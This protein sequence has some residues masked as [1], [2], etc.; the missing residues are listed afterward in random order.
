MR[1]SQPRTWLTWYSNAFS[2][3]E[4]PRLMVLSCKS[5]LRKYLAE[6]ATI[7]A[8]RMPFSH[9]SFALSKTMPRY[10]MFKPDKW[11]SSDNSSELVIGRSSPS[12]Y[13][14][15]VATLSG[16]VFET[17][18]SRLIASLV[19]VGTLTLLSIALRFP[20]LNSKSSY[21]SSC[22]ISALKRFKLLPARLKP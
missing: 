21:S 13:C 17:S 3:E 8:K 12:I 22:R 10:R 1:L 5:Y 9:V 16:M 7:S 15:K 4:A 19:S 20:P 2:R 14:T 6:R 11:S 18:V